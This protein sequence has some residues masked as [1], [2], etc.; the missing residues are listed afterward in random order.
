[1]PAA[2]PSGTPRVRTRLTRAWVTVACGETPSEHTVTLTS[3]GAVATCHDAELDDVITALGG[4]MH[5]CGQVQASFRAAQEIVAA[6]AG[7]RD[8]PGARRFP[9]SGWK[10][11]TTCPSCSHYTSLYI[12]HLMSA[13]HRAF[14]HGGLP[15]VVSRLTA[16]LV[17][18]VDGEVLRLQ[19][20]RYAA[21]TTTKSALRWINGG[22]PLDATNLASLVLHPSYVEPA[23]RLVGNTAEGILTL[24]ESGVRVEWVRELAALVNPD[25][26]RSARRENRSLAPAL[27]AARNVP[28]RLVAQYLNAGIYAHFHT[29]ATVN[30]HPRDILAVYHGSGRTVTLAELLRDG[31]T[32]PGALARFAA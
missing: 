25:A 2:P 9:R 29:Y 13:E 10:D 31:E 1:M 32:I 4:P 5:A 18:N 14:A 30:A 22:R 19:R 12:D 7:Q 26:M 8:I 20:G 3:D 6:A 23:A 28:P 21:S 15:H 16:W 17:R 27:A 11:G 24:R